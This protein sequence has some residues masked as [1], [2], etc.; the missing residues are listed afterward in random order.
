MRF[1]IQDFYLDSTADL[2]AVYKEISVEIKIFH[3]QICAC[4]P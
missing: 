4:G 1:I 3:T 2:F